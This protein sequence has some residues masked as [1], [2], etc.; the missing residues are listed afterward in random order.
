MRGERWYHR[1]FAGLIFVAA[2]LELVTLLRRRDRET[3]SSYVRSKVQHPAMR[4]ALGGLLGW[5]L[6][7]WLAPT[8]DLSWRDGASTVGGLLIGVVS[9]IVAKRIRA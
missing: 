4:V 7:H 9:V 6:Y 8:T 1:A 3:M 5:L 2:A